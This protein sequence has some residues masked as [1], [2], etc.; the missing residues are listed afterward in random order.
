MGGMMGLMILVVPA[1]IEQGQR[2]RRY[3]LDTGVHDPEV[4]VV[5]DD[6]R[7]F[8]DGFG[9]SVRGLNTGDHIRC[10]PGWSDRTDVAVVDRLIE[11]MARQGDGGYEWRQVFEWEME[12]PDLNDAAAVEAWL[13]A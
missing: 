12:L 4:V 2:Y 1:T 11:L 9:S 6:A 10:L 7:A 5:P 3:L 8:L 13:S